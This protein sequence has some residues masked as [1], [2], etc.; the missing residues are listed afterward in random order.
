M[1]SKVLV[2]RILQQYGYEPSSI[3]DAQSGYRSESFRVTLADETFINL[4]I[5]KREPEILLKIHNANRIGNYLTS[6]GLPIR[7]AID[8]R[9]I[10]LGTD[11]TAAYGALYNYLPGETIPWEAYT[12]VHIKQ[13]GCTLSM[14]HARVASQPR[15]DLPL[16][17]DEY[18]ALYKRMQAYFTQ[19][20]V[21]SALRSKLHL[22]P[23]ILTPQL[24]LIRSHK[25]DAGQPLHM[26][27]VRGN[28]LFKPNSAEITGIIDFEKV[29]WGPVVF[30]IARTLAFLL[31]DCKYKEPAKIRKYFLHSG[32]NKRGTAQFRE[33]AELERVI[34]IFLLHDFYKFLLHNPYESLRHNEHFR[35]TLAILLQ[36]NLLIRT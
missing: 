29:A 15:G 19:A 10:R 27:F 22:Q 32:Y 33:Y 3:A 16:V 30:D 7:H 2:T 9:I 6:Q 21:R 34:D 26:D 14:L 23:P 12:R 8:P 35:R 28:I 18:D 13:L 25:N 4:I 20:G 31:V 11:G 24:D 1:A 17:T 36:R 5:Y